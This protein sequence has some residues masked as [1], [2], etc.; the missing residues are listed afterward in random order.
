MPKK[1]TKDAFGAFVRALGGIIMLIAVAAAIMF[2]AYDRGAFESCGARESEERYY[3]PPLPKKGELSVYCLDVGQGD[4]FLLVSPDQRAMLIDSGDA[5]YS[6]RVIAVLSRLGIKQLDTVVL[7]HPHTDHIGAMADI[8]KEFGA[9]NC[10]LPDAPF[11]NAALAAAESALEAAGA[12]KRYLW[13]GD[14]FFLGSDVEITVLSPVHGCEY[15]LDDANDWCLM[16]RVEYGETALLFTADAT[17]HAQLI[18][19]FHNEKE[20]F[21]ADAVKVPH[22]GAASSASLGFFETVSAE[23]ALISCGAKNPYGHPDASTLLALDS[24]GAKVLRTDRDGFITLFSNGKNLTAICE[25][26]P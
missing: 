5:V 20:L 18:S 11:D 19:M 7:T 3:T 25:K 9:K 16:L 14:K 10:C 17:V 12:N 4:S 2:V 26:Q 24:V 13:S 1:R 22:H 23:Y 21:E 8:V 15:A 6:R